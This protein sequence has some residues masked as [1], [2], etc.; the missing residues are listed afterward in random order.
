MSMLSTPQAARYQTAL[1]VIGQRIAELSA[2]ID[3]ERK[4]GAPSEGRILNLVE[5]REQLTDQQERLSPHNADA[6]ERVLT[7]ATA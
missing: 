5:Q 1:Q 2:A 7:G 3:V 6:I 4:A